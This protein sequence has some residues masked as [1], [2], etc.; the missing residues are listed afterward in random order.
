M[1]TNGLAIGNLVLGS[2]GDAEVASLAG[3][4]RETRA[5]TAAASPRY[6]TIDLLRGYAI[7]GVVLLHIS[8]LLSSSGQTVGASLPKWLKYMI[9]TQGGNGVSAFFSISGFLITL[10]SFRRFGKLESISLKTF[11]RIRFARIA[12]LLFL[13]LALLSV[14]H[15]YGPAGFH[16]RPSVGS[17]PHALFAALT[18]QTNWFEAVHGWLPASWSVLWSL[19]VEEMFYLF[20]PLLCA[21]LL[22][23][24][25]GKAIFFA[26][27]VFLI[28]FGPFARTPWYTSNAIWGYQSYLG[29]LDNVALGCLFG[30]IAHRLSMSSS[31]LRSRWPLY[32]Q[33]LGSAMI[34]F[35]VDWMWPRV[36]FGW[37]IKR[38]LGTSG[39]DVTVLGLGVCLV[40]LGSV[41]RES[42]GSRLTLPIRWLGRYSYEV[43]LTHDLV[44]IALF[45]L[46]TKIHHGP[47]TAWIIAAIVLS[48][49]V[50]H[51]ISALFSEPLN[52]LL[53]GAPLPSQLEA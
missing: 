13:L 8:I 30:L 24:R 11:Y 15:L 47:V 38:A 6:D 36:I 49:V 40:M 52:R 25:W 26:V 12:P 3:P 16:I 37:H 4:R 21:I 27:L 19:S 14:L 31:F 9:F 50:G 34:L 48:G 5:V 1:S 53:R 23:R 51:Y 43:Y 29:N 46:Y 10:V 35:I 39:T 33:I 20:F 7:L 2:S 45:T 42:R 18:F 17:L 44:I 28:G 32:V 41:L 22:P